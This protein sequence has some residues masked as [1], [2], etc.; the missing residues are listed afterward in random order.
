MTTEAKIQLTSTELGRL[1]MT[2]QIKTAMLEI[3][4]QFRESTIDVE[5][6]DILN[7]SVI[8]SQNIISEIVKIFNSQ[9]AVIPKGFDDRDIFKDAPPLF[10]DIFNIMFLRQIL[11]MN[12]G[13]SSLYLATAYM[14][15]VQ[16]LFALD[17]TVSKKL[18]VLSTE[19]LLKKGVLAKPP[20]V[21]APNKVEFIES[22]KYVNVIN[23]FSDK[24]A[25][26]TVEIGYIYEFIDDNILGMQLK[27]GFAQVAQESDVNKFL[28]ESKELSKKIITNLTS[29]FLQSDI[30]PPSTWAGKATTSIQPPFSD[31][32]MMFVVDLISNFA[33]GAN[34]LGSSFSMRSD[35][36]FVF[37]KITKDL[38]SL[39][40]KGGKLMIRHMW[41]EEPPQ[42]EDRNQLT[43]FKK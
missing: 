2:Y 25:L 30:Q 40:K 38:L 39:S 28:I 23:I 34:S 36:P 19:Y 21:T 31:K 29:V 33:V 16:E 13:F 17:H 3:F 9:D 43:K 42:M 10:D 8:E 37:A 12:V 41:M 6:K 5:A 18:Y 22:E 1:W 15:E 32:L 26:N 7:S 11:K 35:L 4:K 14:K 20:Y 24:R 27:T